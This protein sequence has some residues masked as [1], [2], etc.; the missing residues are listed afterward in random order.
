MRSIKLL[1]I[2]GLA[3]VASLATL[4]SADV[5]LPRIF[6][7]NMVLQRDADDVIWGWADPGEAVTLTLD[8]QASIQATPNEKG[9]WS[10]RLPATA[11]GGPH[12]LAIQGRN[13]IDLNNVLFGEVWICSGQ[14]NMEMGMKMVKN[15]QQD[16][17]AA[18][19]PQIR[20]FM[21]DKKTSGTPVDDVSGAWKVCNPQNL[22]FGGWNG[23][24]AAAFYFGRELNKELNVPVGLIDTSWGG[25]RIEPWTPPAGF[26]SVPALSSISQ[27]IEQTN[28]DYRKAYLATLDQIEAAIP[29]I[30]KRVQNG[31]P[32]PQ[33]PALP[34]HALD[35]EQQPTG[36]FNSM[37]NG[38]VPLTVRG[39]IWYQGES[40]LGEGMLYHEKMKALINGW[41]TVFNNPQ[42]PFYF[43]QIAP[44]N[45]GGDPS[46]LPQ[47][48]EAQAATLS[49]P[50]TGM[51]VITDVATL[52]NIHPPDKQ[53]VGHRLALWALAN[54]YGKK[55]VVYSGPLYK[56]MAVEGSK[57]KLTF[58]HVGSGLASRDGKDLTWFEIAGPDKNFVK[59]SARIDGDSVVVWNDQVTQP[60]A[61][62]FAWSQ[63]AE[64]NLMNKEGLPASAFRTDH[65]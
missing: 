61:V 34:K 21:V 35:N 65:P 47:I 17:Q 43:V 24:S 29:N 9:E 50:H 14:S 18:N 8:Q 4:A 6:A 60:T 5:R 59:A 20:L 33:L 44:F 38:F 55:D 49:V 52:N 12:K 7:S 39:A 15:G 63:L 40:N 53:T 41:R 36:L 42:M 1:M 2:A 64:P 28:A 22:A 23:F 3:S 27:R 46:R 32:I 51:A 30:R 13:H 26:S 54:T 57:V 56:S 25:T 19:L 37:V 16:I 31:G 10:A 62:R 11:A 45:Y 58:D 48:W